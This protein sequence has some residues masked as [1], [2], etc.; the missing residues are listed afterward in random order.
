MN[1]QDAID[2]VTGAAWQ[3]GLFDAVTGHEPKAAPGRTG[4]T[5]SAWIQAWRPTQSSGMASAS[6]RLTV[7][8]RIYCPMLVEPQDMID[9]MVMTA[10]DAVFAYVA[11]HFQAGGIGQTRYVDLLGSDGEE[12][13]AEL[14]YAEQNKAMFRIADVSI[15]VIINDL[16]PYA[17]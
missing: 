12:M 4:L 16:Y 15:P 2:Y 8:L 10:V 11:S 1:F 6:M 14:G 9:P 5:A 7:Q 17:A 3:T 13:N